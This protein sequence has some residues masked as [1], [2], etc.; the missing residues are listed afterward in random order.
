MGRIYER[1]TSRSYFDYA[2]GERE[3]LDEIITRIGALER[4]VATL[5]L[6]IA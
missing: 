3:K 5:S 1:R 4:E 6:R 2:A